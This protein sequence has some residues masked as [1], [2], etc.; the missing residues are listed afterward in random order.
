MATPE[1]SAPQQDAM[2][3]QF[4]GA[5]LVAHDAAIDEL[6]DPNS[7]LSART[8]EG[9]AVREA[10]QPATAAQ[11]AERQMGISAADHANREQAGLPPRVHN[12]Q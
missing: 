9:A 6:L 2:Q 1:S 5:E 8:V 10:V 4:S 3:S 12:L 11:E 7:D